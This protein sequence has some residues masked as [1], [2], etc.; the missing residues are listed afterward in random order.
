VSNSARKEA[1]LSS[2]KKML[3]RKITSRFHFQAKP[4]SQLPEREVKFDFEYWIVL[5]LRLQVLNQTKDE[6]HSNQRHHT[7]QR[8]CS[9]SPFGSMATLML[10]LTVAQFASTPAA[11]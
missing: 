2:S 3:Q 6:Q 4:K 11:R 10:P 9:L 1:R 8:N 5:E 7:T